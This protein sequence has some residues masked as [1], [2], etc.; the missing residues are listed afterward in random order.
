MKKEVP[1]IPI[2]RISCRKKKKVNSFQNTK[3]MKIIISWQILRDWSRV[4]CNF[5]IKSR[6]YSCSFACWMESQSPTTRNPFLVPQHSVYMRSNWTVVRNLSLSYELCS[7]ILV[8]FKE[9]RSN[10]IGK[11][12]SHLT[13]KLCGS[14]LKYSLF[15]KV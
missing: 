11:K 2:R 1:F 5:T 15:Y 14:I 3:T 7:L 10:S 4:P 8:V 6:T 13:I 9:A 12:T